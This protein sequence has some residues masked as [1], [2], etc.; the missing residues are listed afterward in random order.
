MPNKI[1]IGDTVSYGNGSGKGKVTHIKSERPDFKLSK[2]KPVD[3]SAKVTHYKVDGKYWNA[4][5]VKAVRK[6]AKKAK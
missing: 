6:P 2:G 4:S 1:N 5:G 3:K